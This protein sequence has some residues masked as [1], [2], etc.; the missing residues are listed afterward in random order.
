MRFD[1]YVQSGFAQLSGMKTIV[2][3]L[4][5]TLLLQAKVH[6]AEIRYSF[7]NLKVRNSST[8]ILSKGMKGEGIRVAFIG[9]S[10]TANVRGHS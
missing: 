6:A 7:D 2:A 5:L 4:S 1:L 10:I 8:R 9:G 3:A